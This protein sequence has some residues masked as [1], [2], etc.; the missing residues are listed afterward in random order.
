[1]RLSG[2]CL[3]CQGL[4]SLL[5][6][7]QSDI[8]ITAAGEVYISENSDTVQEL[9]R[10]ENQVAQTCRPCKHRPPKLRLLDVRHLCTAFFPCRRFTF[11]HFFLRTDIPSPLAHTPALLQYRH[12]S[13]T[14]L[15]QRSPSLLPPPFSPC[16]SLA[17]ISLAAASHEA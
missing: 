6:R 13:P 15:S 4:L 14:W 3:P 5:G 7:A 12:L 10:N 1:M 17:S 11:C 2:E 8:V 16:R 9:R